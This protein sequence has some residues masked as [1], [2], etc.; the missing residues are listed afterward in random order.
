[1]SVCHMHSVSVAARRGHQNPLKLELQTIVNGH[2]C[3][4]NQKPAFLTSE[5]MVF[6][7]TEPS[8]QPEQLV[9]KKERARR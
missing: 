2:V 3:A 7:A 5:Q 9:I 6:L 4:E 8:L 1:M